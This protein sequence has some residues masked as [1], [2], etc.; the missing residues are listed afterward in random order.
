MS[1]SVLRL[2]GHPE[3]DPPE[4]IAWVMPTDVDA[5]Q[6]HQ[7]HHPCPEKPACGS[8]QG[9]DAGCQRGV[10]GNRLA[11]E[12]TALWVRV[13][14]PWVETGNAGVMNGRRPDD[15]CLRNRY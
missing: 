11:G 13:D 15:Q 14:I 10:K 12:G 1:L 7:N 9:I 2:A 5:R 3:D 4:D 6:A 8:V